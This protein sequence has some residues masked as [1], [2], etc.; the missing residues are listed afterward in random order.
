MKVTMRTG[1]PDLAEIY[2]AQL[3]DDPKYSV[4]FV[5]SCGT[6]G[7]DRR[8]KWVAIISTQFGCPAGCL[9]CDA[10]GGYHGDLS[11]EEMIWQLETVLA[12]HPEVNPRS[13]RKLKFQFARMGEP[14]LNDEVL[15]VLKWL[16]ANY[17]RCIPCV[18][19]L[20]PAGREEWF[21][22]L[23]AGRDRFADFQLQFSI[24][25]TDRELRDLLM[26]V[27]KQPWEW[28]AEYGQ[29]FRRPGA[30]KAGLNFALSDSIPV[31]AAEV[32][33]HFDPEAFAVKLTPLNPTGSGLANELE[34]PD[35]EADCREL[36]ELRAAQFA[37]HGFDVIRSV[38]EWEENRIG[39]NCGQLVRALAGTV[40]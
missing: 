27:D 19:T 23:L 2:L 14:S 1:R 22:E 24:N 6:A 3:R 18:T 25:T 8:E 13:C 32:A 20:A 17:P 11:R 30:R 16:G 36:V 12:A 21:A 38:G 9:M 39:S 31:D 34:P 4:E 15:P 37:A 10:G 40:V 35:N 33:R 29:A 5:D 28:I 26:P 7:G